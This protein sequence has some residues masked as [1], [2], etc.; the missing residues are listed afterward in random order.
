[1]ANNIL[2]YDINRNSGKTK[3]DKNTWEKENS[4]YKDFYEKLMKETNEYTNQWDKFVKMDYVNDLY[5]YYVKDYPT[6]DL[7]KIFNETENAEK[8]YSK[9]LLYRYNSLFPKEQ[10][11][12]DANRTDT[13]LKTQRNKYL[14]KVIRAS[15]NVENLETDDEVLDAINE[16]SLQ[17]NEIKALMAS[18]KTKEEL[19]VRIRIN[20]LINDINEKFETLITEEDTPTF[21]QKHLLDEKRLIQQFKRKGLKETDLLNYLTEVNKYNFDQTLEQE[22]AKYNSKRENKVELEDLIKQY[23]TPYEILAHITLGP[24]VEEYNNIFGTTYKDLHLVLQVYGFDLEYT[25]RECER[26]IIFRKFHKTYPKSGAHPT[27]PTYEAY[28]NQNGYTGSEP[29]VE[30]LTNYMRKELSFVEG[31]TNHE[32]TDK[33]TKY[34]KDKEDESQRIAQ[35]DIL[36]LSS[37]A[38]D[39]ELII[40]ILQNIDK[41]NNKFNTKYD[42]TNIKELCN[43]K[44]KPDW[45][46]AYKK[47]RMLPVIQDYNEVAEKNNSE[48]INYLGVLKGAKLREDNVSKDQVDNFV[49]GLEDATKLLKKNYLQ[50]LYDDYLKTTEDTK[51]FKNID[52]FLEKHPDFLD[53]EKFLR[54]NKLVVL[55]NKISEELRTKYKKDAKDVNYAEY[56][57]TSDINQSEFILAST[58]EKVFKI[59]EEEKKKEQETNERNRIVRGKLNQL[60]RIRS[61]L[62]LNEYT[63]DRYKDIPVQEASKMVDEDISDAQKREDDKNKSTNTTI[64]GGATGVPMRFTGPTSNGTPMIPQKTIN[65]LLSTP[66]STTTTPPT[67]KPNNDDDDDDKPPNSSI[68]FKPVNTEF[69]GYKG[70]V[71][72]L[73]E[74][75][76]KGLSLRSLWLKR[77]KEGGA[78]PPPLIPRT[79]GNQPFPVRTFT[80][81]GEK[82]IISTPANGQPPPITKQDSDDEDSE[83]DDFKSDEEESEE[84]PPKKKPAKKKPKKVESDDDDEEES[85]EEP[86]KKKP[87]KKK[88]TLKKAPKKKPVKKPKKVESDDFDDDELEDDYSEEEPPKKKPAKKKTTLKKAPKKKPVKKN[89]LKKTPKKKAPPKK[90]PKKVESDDFDDDISDDISEDISEEEPPK[91]F[92]FNLKNLKL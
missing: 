64:I 91:K 88:T 20:T 51:S 44:I 54:L 34:N 13:E 22:L 70:G 87:A 92:K 56:E 12:Y 82:P 60:N 38:D 43:N 45:I 11:E 73:V 55:I 36:K 71:I 62:G 61:R 32:L 5:N 10:I 50:P 67:T 83:K 3:Y 86:P 29:E 1:M 47:V 8:A 26:R 58:L 80:G 85:E 40:A 27:F 53:A 41:F 69:S 79:D 21:I 23:G 76:E 42:K 59:Q 31:L 77:Q 16:S 2:I 66:P 28:L 15:I 48:K 68:R 46:N 18:S 17:E 49:K 24:L 6:A 81:P 7:Q 25:F 75:T 37:T 52:D 14:Q 74:K 72:N 33:L 30:D 4:D 89:T 35:E 19:I 90:K 63:M 39:I 57:K 9:L 65:P 78:A 84:E